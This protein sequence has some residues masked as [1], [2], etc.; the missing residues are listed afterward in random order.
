MKLKKINLKKIN[1]KKLS[2]KKKILLI[3][4][5]LAVIGVI[6]LRIHQKKAAQAA[7]ALTEASEDTTVLRQD[8]IQSLSAN[9]TLSPLNSYK[10]TAASNIEGTI[11]KADFKEG[12]VVKKGEVLYRIGSDTLSAKIESA[13]KSVER[14]KEKYKKTQSSYNKTLADCSEFSVTAKNSGYISKLEVSVGDTLSAG[15]TTVAVVNDKKHITIKLPFLQNQVSASNVGQSASVTLS[16]TGERLR[17]T[18]TEVDSYS[19]SYAGNRIVKYVTIRLNNNGALSDGVTATAT[20][21]NVSCVDEAAF[22][23]STDQNQVSQISGK[24][25]NIVVKEGAPPFTNSIM[26]ASPVLNR[27]SSVSS[28]LTG[29]L[30][31]T[32]RTSPTRTSFRSSSNSPSWR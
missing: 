31:K 27:I 4:I 10:V 16:A 6:A 17:G 24:V 29:F 9:G 19:Q 22:I 5:L 30:R 11:L 7:L 14:A 13:R 8:I 32:Y 21:G 15:A 25:A 20:I 2:K 3:I 26:A 18:V 28:R 1:L 23:A 12:D